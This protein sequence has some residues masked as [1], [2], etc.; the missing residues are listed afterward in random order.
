MDRVTNLKVWVRLPRLPIQFREERIIGNILQPIGT[1][2]KV[3]EVT[4]SKLNGLFVWVLME[5]D[6]RFSLNRVIIVNKDEDN[7]ILI[8]NQKL[9]RKD[10]HCL[11]DQLWSTY[12]NVLRVIVEM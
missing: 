5:V 7:P 12:A 4:F 2:V 8:T 3:D 11:V 6:L 10:L 1:T 9:F